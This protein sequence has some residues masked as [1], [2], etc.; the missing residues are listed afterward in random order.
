MAP[1]KMKA[2]KVVEK[3]KAEIQ[4]VPLPKLRDDY[5][6]V[7]VKMV[8]LNPTDWK[9]IDFLP[10]V[11]HTVGCDFVGTIEEVGSKVKKPWKKGD[12]MASWSHGV[13]SAE[14]ED[15][16]F[17]DYLVAKGDIGMKVPENV[18]DEEAATL[19][20]G[21]STVGQGLYQSLGLPLP[22]EKKAG[23]PLLVY[24][25]STATGTLAIQ[26]AKLSGCEVI[27]TC[28]KKNFDL[29]KSLGASEAFD[30]NDPDVAKKIREHTK[31]QLAHVFDCISEGDSPKISSESIG[32]KGGK[33]SYL[34]PTKHERTD[35]EN[36]S[37]LGYTIFGEAFNF[38]G[39]DIPANHED[40]TKGAAFWA[41]AEKLL[42]E[43]KLKVHPPKVEKG[44]L[45][46]V[47]DGMQQLKEG[48]VSGTKLVYQIGETS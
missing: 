32:S 31:D 11:G 8:A 25:G 43:G 4:E 12:R 22:G 35:V 30:Y 15:G 13:N 3:G 45:K 47:F 1:S 37:T 29:V 38:A 28:S 9:H 39:N 36:K 14:A 33:V 44:G 7:K 42:A 48:K 17:A 34:L 2:I 19:G 40:F 23:Y 16:A 5:V 10:Q 41:L 27:T 6:L 46:G 24:G 26:F 20:V 21:I 18:S